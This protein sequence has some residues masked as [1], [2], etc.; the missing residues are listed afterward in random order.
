[1]LLP[2]GRL[3][4]DFMNAKKVIQNLVPSEVKVLEG[5]HFDIKRTC[6]G[7]HIY[8]YIQVNDN[9]HV[10]QYMERVQALVLADF[11]SLL[12]TNFEIIGTF[13]SYDLNV[14]HED[15]SDR[16]ILLAQIKK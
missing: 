14:F 3:L 2:G 1:M 5:L 10:S 9:G 6:D 15:I 13:G 12:E 7:K 16:L 11:L 8:K 4:I